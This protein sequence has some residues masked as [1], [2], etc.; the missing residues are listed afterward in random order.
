MSGLYSTSFSPWFSRKYAYL[1]FIS[2]YNTY[3]S[4][5]Q[6][7][8][9]ISLLGYLK[10]K[11]CSL[12]CTFSRKFDQPIQIWGTKNEQ[13]HVFDHYRQSTGKNRE[14]KHKI[15]S[16]RAGIYWKRYSYSTNRATAP[17]IYLATKIS[18]A[19]SRVP[20]LSKVAAAW[21]PN[22]IS[23]AL[24]DNKDIRNLAVKIDITVYYLPAV[25]DTWCKASQY[26]I[27]VCWKGTTKVPRPNGKVVGQNGS[28]ILR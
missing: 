10:I 26:S 4:S 16:L 24:L 5:P 7:L 14:R 21:G 6:F 13:Q 22:A 28:T 18:F 8:V 3:T 11:I 17:A 2:C 19:S 27:E 9:N 25:V 1:H 12:F 23:V 15:K 20:V